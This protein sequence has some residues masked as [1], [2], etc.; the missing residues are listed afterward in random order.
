MMEGKEKSYLSVK[1]QTRARERRV[2][3]IGPSEY[4]I[5]VIS[6]PS[7]GMANK[8]VVQ[9]LADY[10]TLPP[11]QVKIISGT[12]SARKRI[13][14]EMRGQIVTGYGRDKKSG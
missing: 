5:S 4:R 10:F 6:P 13:L 11:S 9:T 2:V 14:V 7:K 12:K 1:V 8:E 3:R